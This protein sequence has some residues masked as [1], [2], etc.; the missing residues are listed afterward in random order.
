RCAIRVHSPEARCS[1]RARLMDIR[2]RARGALLASLAIV[3]FS[4]GIPAPA[5]ATGASGKKSATP[6]NRPTAASANAACLGRALGGMENIARVSTI[7][8]RSLFEAGGLRGTD[9]FWRDVRGAVRESLD[10]P[11]AFSALV[12]FDGVKGWRR[13][14]NG[15]VLAL[16]GV[17]LE[18]RVT[19]A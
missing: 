14:S 6:H 9:V 1:R 19:D 4:A 18:D 8:T 5:P 11:G 17:D 2:Q 16:S 10:V 13:G 3:S 7:S 12:V 15:G